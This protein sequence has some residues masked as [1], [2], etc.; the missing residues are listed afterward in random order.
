MKRVLASDNPYSRAKD[1]T[2]PTLSNAVLIDIE[3]IQRLA[4]LE[5]EGLRE[6][7]RRRYIVAGKDDFLNLVGHL[8]LFNSV[9]EEPSPDDLNSPRSA[10]RLMFRSLKYALEHKRLVSCIPQLAEFYQKYG[11]GS[12]LFI[13][14][15]RLSQRCSQPIPNLNLPEANAF[16]D[17]SGNLAR[18]KEEVDAFAQH[19]RRQH[20]L[21]TGVQGT[22]KSSAIHWALG[23]HK[24]DNLMLIA[25]RKE[26][27]FNLDELFEA[28]ET[29]PQQ[30]ILFFDDLSFTAIDDDY[31]RLKA[32]LEGELR[33]VPEHCAIYATS[34]L[35]Q[36]MREE[37]SDE[38]NEQL[39][40]SPHFGL[41][42]HFPQPV[43]CDYLTI[44]E[45]LFN[46][47]N[48]TWTDKVKQE[49]LQFAK[50]KGHY[51]PRT[52]QQFLRFWS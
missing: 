12:R 24:A 27:L 23:Q 13:L 36:L 44:V 22:G 11:T 41:H 1:P 6:E 2:Q 19:K 5:S 8:P 26:E 45:Y 39:P 16:I 51:T 10:W 43:Q 3:T 50:Q 28:L 4:S 20:V 9:C 37:D 17:Y 52:A 40:L 46:R 47:A 18:L 29:C 15:L 25:L 7:I 48:Q 31:L 33:S 35:C 14:C 49:A 32:Y 38:Q 21:L 34:N 30:V 42:L